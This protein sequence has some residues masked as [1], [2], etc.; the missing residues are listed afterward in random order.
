ML[1]F[2]SR[3]LRGCES[4]KKGR[5]RASRDVVFCESILSLSSCWQPSSSPASA[6]VRPPNPARPCITPTLF[7][8]RKAS[9]SHIIAA[10]FD[11]SVHVR[12]HRTEAPS[13][14]ARA[15]QSFTLARVCCLA[16]ALHPSMTLLLH[17]HNSHSQSHISGSSI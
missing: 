13:Q 7:S 4:Y 1:T 17:S 16:V 9:F 15:I 6:R 11:T 2:L 12:H 14:P 8:C 5:S 3:S 10:A